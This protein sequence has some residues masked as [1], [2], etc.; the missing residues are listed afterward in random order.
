MGVDVFVHWVPG[1]PAELANKI[2]QNLPAHVKLHMITNRGTVVW[3]GG[4]EETFLTDHW[5]TRVLS[6][7]G[8]PLTHKD[9]LAILEAY[10]RAG[11]DFIK[12]EHLY[13]FDGVDAYS[14]GQ[15]E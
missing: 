10:H 5:R 13:R 2:E 14:K 1:K 3:P 6:K 8:S 15:G 7:D 11:L 4:L 12:T 9:I